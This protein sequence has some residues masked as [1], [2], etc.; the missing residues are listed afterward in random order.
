M[1]YRGED[2]SRTPADWGH[3][4]PRQS[5]PAMGQGSAGSWADG[6][7]GYGNGEYDDYASDGT[8]YGYQRGDGY[9]G[10][11][12]QE[13]GQYGQGDPYGP[14]APYG[15]PAGY[16]Q[17]AGYGQ[18]ADYGYQQAAGPDAGYAAGQG[19][20]S[21][22]G[23]QDHYRQ[24]EPGYGVPGGDGPGYQAP[25]DGYGQR[26]VYPARHGGS[27]SYPALTDGADGYQG[28]DAGNDW[29][30]GQPAAASG[31]GFADTGTYALNSRVIDD[32]GTDPNETLRNP[33]RGYPPTPGQPQGPAQTLGRTSLP[34]PAQPVIS[35]PQAVPRS[36]SQEQYD[37][38]DSY[39]G[40]GRDQ[41]Q[42]RGHRSPTGEYPATGRNPTGEYPTTVGNATGGYPA[43]GR[44]PTGEYPTT[45]GN[46]TG[47]YPAVGRNPTGEYP[48]TVG[49]PT[50][51]YPAAGRNPT[52]G[53]PTTV[54]NPTGGYP[55]AGRNPT[56]EYPTTVGNPTGEYPTTV[57]NST[58]G[59]PGAGRNATGEYPTTVRNPTGGYPAPASDDYD[60]YAP[61][62]YGQDF[63]YGQSGQRG[64]NSGAD[65]ANP[66]VGYDGYPADDPYQDRY[67]EGAG[68]RGPGKGGR[69]KTKN[70][71]ARKSARP[72][73]Q[74]SPGGKRPRTLAVTIGTLCVVV[75]AAAAAYFLVLKPHSSTPNPDAGGRL[76]T[77]G[78]SPSDQACVQQ[79]GTYCHI[80]SRTLDPAALTL[81]ELFPPVVNNE[82]NGGGNITS[83]FTME[84]NK[85]DTKCSGAVIGQSL[86]SAL[87]TGQCS[88]VLRASYLSGDGKIMGTIGVINLSSTNQAHYAGKVVGQNDFIAPLA[89]KKG[90]ASKLGQGT[91]V[92]EAQYKGHYLILTWSE[93]VNGATPSTTAQDN[94]LEAFSSDL[95]AGTANIN[96]S[97]RMVS[98]DTK[99]DSGS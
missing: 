89:A 21:Q 61:D 43:A 82:A 87:Q 93:F 12:Q 2:V 41:Y 40:Y 58:G 81:A 64:L 90:V 34:A 28:R 27:G 51:G 94:Q 85:L 36:G 77:A 6:A 65:Y 55:A 4:A 1:G 50:G 16:E 70:R 79:L 54:R 83:S 68:G 59:Y 52:G 19:P 39:P 15:E 91:G 78:A 49:N 25:D 99:A 17:P 18:S 98:G 7:Q 8:G 35:G 30:G 56:G 14:Q 46:P 86:I 24:L 45:V 92:V 48:T 76:P 80:Q 69:A 73:R 10:Y 37:D 84:T 20:E 44:N 57:D 5:S 38:Y 11:P 75:V 74:A 95:V 63:D 67:A 3:Q 42:D 96:L 66:A 31:A 9:G 33:V 62:A 71:T 32:Y 26:D 47:G 13:Q 29:Y 72:T 88:Q 53:Y 23:Q 97:E 22:Y 60:A